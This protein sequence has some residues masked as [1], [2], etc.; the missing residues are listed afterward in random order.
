VS[1]SS[2]V[3]TS[4]EQATDSYQGYVSMASE[5]LAGRGIDQSLAN[6]FRLGVVAEPIIGHELYEGRL[7]I[8]YV[9]RSGVVYMKFACMLGHDHHD[10][11]VTCPKYM[12]IASS[13]HIYNVNDFFRDSSYIAMAEGEHD[14]QILSRYVCPAVGVPGVKN[15]KPHYER[16]F[17]D[18]ERV[19]MFADGD[20]YGKD[21]A[22]FISQTLDSVTVIHMPDGEDVNSMF[23]AEGPDGLK[24]R[25][26]L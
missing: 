5:Y 4:L 18:Y 25:A 7:S 14:T 8:P 6:T 23:M 1:L 10:E 12:N 21:F 19:F 16:L 24:K 26:G 20:K 9:T 15:W 22:R 2:S 3:R 11:S 17:Q 13:T